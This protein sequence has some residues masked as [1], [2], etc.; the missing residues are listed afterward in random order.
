MVL[1]Q[2][3]FVY[4]DTDEK[5]QIKFRKSK[6]LSFTYVFIYFWGEKSTL[7]S[8]TNIKHIP[9]IHDPGGAVTITIAI[10]NPRHVVYW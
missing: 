4:M 2:E 9:R 6:Y 7:H 5:S 1:L 3:R 8:S 10:G